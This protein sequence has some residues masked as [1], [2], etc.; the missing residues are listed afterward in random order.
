MSYIAFDLG[1]KVFIRFNLAT[2]F[3]RIA[4]FRGQVVSACGALLQPVRPEVILRTG[5][6]E[7]FSGVHLFATGIS[8]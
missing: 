5:A 3:G 8:H 6:P 1:L 4:S 7:S 2:T